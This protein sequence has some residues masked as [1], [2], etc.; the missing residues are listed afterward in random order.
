MSNPISPPSAQETQAV[1]DALRKAVAKTLERKRRLGQYAIVWSGNAPI[2]IG[3]D[4]PVEL[5]AKSPSN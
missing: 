3:E 4:A 5:K 1:W 2:A